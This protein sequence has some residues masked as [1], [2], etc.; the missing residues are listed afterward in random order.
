MRQYELFCYF[1][2]VLPCGLVA[3]TFAENYSFC[4]EGLCRGRQ[5]D[6]INLECLV[7]HSAFGFVAP[8]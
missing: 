3:Y 8:D 4:A 5:R 6:F 1:D 2:R 7:F